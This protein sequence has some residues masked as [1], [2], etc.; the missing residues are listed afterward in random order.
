MP[1][2]GGFIFAENPAIAAP[3]A[4]LIW[5]AD[6]DPGTILVEA[7]PALRDEGDAIDPRALAAWLTLATNPDGREHAVLSDGRHHIRFDVGAGTLMSGP[8]MLR[9][10]LAGTVSAQAKL[11]PLRRLVEFCIDRRFRAALYPPDPRVERW[12]VALRVHDG[13]AAGASLR[14]IAGALYGAQRVAADWSDASDSMRSR[15]RRLAAEAR[16][17]ARGG[18]RFLMRGRPA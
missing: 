5:H 11:L 12:L 7:E 16:R 6:L 8:V 9:Y 14:E 3:Q 2:P 13:L 15:V 17:L 10:R 1:C 4:R 18:Y